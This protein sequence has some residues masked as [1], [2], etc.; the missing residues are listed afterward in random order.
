[1]YSSQSARQPHHSPPR[2]PRRGTQ[3]TPLARA[4]SHLGS[5]FFLAHLMGLEAALAAHSGPGNDAVVLG[6]H[7]NRV[8]EIEGLALTLVLELASFV[9]VEPL[10]AGLG[11]VQIH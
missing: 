2:V 9:L 3:I 6:V 5:A 7:S 10:K 4:V 8:S 11:L 1:M